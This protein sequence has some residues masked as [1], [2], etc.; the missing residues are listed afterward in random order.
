[1]G[2]IAI[3]KSVKNIFKKGAWRVETPSDFGGGPINT[4]TLVLNPGIDSKPLPGDYAYSAP[5]RKTGEFVAPGVVDIKNEPLA[6]EGE[7]RIYAR[8]ASGAAVCQIWA[9]KDGT[10]LIDNG[11]AVFEMQP[12]GDVLING[13]KIT[14]AGDFISKLG[15]SLDNHFHQ[16][17]LSFPTGAT[18]MSGGGTAPSQ[19]PSTNASGDLITG[20]GTSVD[21]HT[22]AYDWTDPAGSGETDP[23]T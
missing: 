11:T 21:L 8:D 6:L 14:A 4:L 3:I 22:H 10:V 20:S 13:A 7:T 9:K 19:L 16:G 23:P 17:N 12:G 1:M 5:T 2:A 15:N 18:I